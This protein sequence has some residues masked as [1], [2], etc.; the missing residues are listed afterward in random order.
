MEA[1]QMLHDSEHLLESQISAIFK[2]ACDRCGI[3]LEDTSLSTL[4]SNSLRDICM[5]H[6]SEFREFTSRVKKMAAFDIIK[7]KLQ[8]D[9]AE[10]CWI[11]ESYPLAK[12]LRRI[13]VKKME[14]CLSKFPLQKGLENAISLQNAYLM[15]PFSEV[16]FSSDLDEVVFWRKLFS[17][18]V[19]SD[20]ISQLLAYSLRLQ[21]AR[22]LSSTRMALFCLEFMSK[23][24]LLRKPGH[25]TLDAMSTKPLISEFCEENIFIPVEGCDS[26]PLEFLVLLQL[27]RCILEFFLSNPKHVTIQNMNAAAG[28]PSSLLMAEAVQRDSSRLS[29][30]KDDL[31]D[32]SRSRFLAMFH[33]SFS[34]SL[35]PNE[36]HFVPHIFNQQ[37]A[38]LFVLLILPSDFQEVIFGGSTLC[39]THE[40]IRNCF[41]RN[42]DL[43]IQ[44][45]VSLISP[46]EVS[47]DRT[48]RLTEFI[49]LIEPFRGLSFRDRTF[50]VEL[51]EFVEF[52]QGQ[53]VYVEG[54]LA[55]HAFLVVAGRF[56]AV[57][58]NNDTE[59]EYESSEESKQRLKNHVVH[60]Y[61]SRACFGTF[62]CQF[63]VPRTTSVVAQEDSSV[64]QIKWDLFDVV[65]RLA[66]G[67]DRWHQA[68]FEPHLIKRLAAQP[69]SF[70]RG[71]SVDDEYAQILSKY[72]RL[73]Q[74]T[75]DLPL[76][77]QLPDHFIVVVD[78][79]MADKS[80]DIILTKGQF[81]GISF[82]GLKLET[83]GSLNVLSNS[84]V[85]A[86]SYE[87]QFELI[88]EVPEFER[89]LLKKVNAARAEFLR[90]LENPVASRPFI[91]FMNSEY[92]Y[93]SE[94]VNFIK[95][96]KEYS[97]ASDE[98]RKKLGNLIIRD[99]MKTTVLFSSLA[100]R[101]QCITQW[102]E[103]G[104]TLDLF[105]EVEQE[106][107][108]TL[109]SEIYPKFKEGGNEQKPKKIIDLAPVGK[110]M[111]D[112]GKMIFGE[113]GNMIGTAVTSPEQK[114]TTTSDSWNVL[115]STS[116][117]PTGGF[118]GSS[119]QSMRSQSNPPSQTRRSQQHQMTSQGSQPIIGQMIMSSI[120][121][122]ALKPAESKTDRRKR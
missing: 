23:F 43:L 36:F 72:F 66:P 106:V 112:V 17:S 121:G 75:K 76:E 107:I 85:L 93:G 50:L 70:F 26:T 60:V 14:V 115:A 41:E 37:L 7:S 31:D 42:L 49:H 120:F 116:A 94:N 35:N 108:N 113:F 88:S 92:Y 18:E 97:Q 80:R 21:G 30:Q 46:E 28:S 20:N 3:E 69:G 86:I 32:A 15:D 117:E 114:E 81:F 24:S 4:S 38:L 11:V 101:Q 45:K 62:E 13:A 40:K 2:R 78:G 34:H 99:F 63:K 58:T 110:T 52:R 1:L 16:R 53:Y 55:E 73:R 47:I 109:Y 87:K 68:D 91:R 33:D 71:L 44:S 95:R 100:V 5:V 79:A 90:F 59:Q 105:S 104:C 96:C 51:C 103:T 9:H 77:A 19:K 84:I 54:N 29:F 118:P 48:R 22:N 83:A 102:C 57:T 12:R 25:R 74:L 111:S 10:D 27:T 6:E 89:H 119:P 82:G 64:L 56:S 39:V 8:I 61:S 98:D 65:N 67:F 122:S